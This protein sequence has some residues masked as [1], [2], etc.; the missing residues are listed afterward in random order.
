MLLRGQ[1]SVSTFGIDEQKE[2]YFAIHSSGKIYKFVGTPATTVAKSDLPGGY[3]LHQNYP[4]PFN[5]ETVISYRLPASGHVSLKV[6]DLLGREV[7]TLVDKF[8]PEGTHN[9]TFTILPS[10]LPTGVYFYKIQ[11]GNFSQVKKMV[12][13]K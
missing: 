6:F 9:S 10:Q 5:P 4:N 1:N 13:M 11:A 12:M 8:Q 7:I 3:R 2:L